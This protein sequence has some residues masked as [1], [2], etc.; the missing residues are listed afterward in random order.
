MSTIKALAGLIAVRTRYLIMAVSLLVVALVAMMVVLWRQHAGPGAAVKALDDSERAWLA[1]KG[2][3]RIAGRWE[4]RPFIFSDEDGNYEGY[5][6]DLAEALG[7]ILG[8]GIEVVSMPREEALI[9]LDNL[10][11]DAIMGL[12]PDAQSSVKYSFSEPYLSSAV[13]VFVRSERLDVTSLEDLQ[14]QEVAVQADTVAEMALSEQP[15]I[16]PVL[17]RS[18]EEGLELVVNEQVRALVA[19]EMAGLQAVQRLGLDG[20]VKLVGLPASSV[21]YSF[22]VPKDDD[23]RL[24]ILNHALASVEAVG[25][26]KQVDRAWFGAPVSVVRATSTSTALTYLLAFLVVGL[27]AGN[28]SYFVLKMRRRAEKQSAILQ[29]SQYKY[30]KLVEGT[31]EAVFSISADMSL[32]EVNTKMEGLT[33]YAKHDVLMR[34]LE[35]LVPTGQRQAIREFVR[36]A[37]QDGAATRDDLSLVDRHGDAVPVQLSAHLLSEGERKIVQCIARDVRERGRMREQV[38]RRSKDLS[39]INLIADKVSSVSDLENTLEEVLATVLNRTGTEGGVIYLRGPRDGE[40]VPAVKQGLTDELMKDLR[41]PQGPRRFADEVVS[42]RKV[43]VSTPFAEQFGPSGSPAAGTGPAIQAGVPLTSK[44]TVHGVMTL[45][46]REP[47]HFT[48][49]D[50]AL[51]TTVG[52]QIGVAIENAEL[53]HQLQ[54]S[55]REMTAVRRFSDSVLEG[56]TNGLVV[57]DREA[58]VRLLNRAG[59]AMLGCKEDEALNRSVEEFLPPGAGMVRDSLERELA[60]SEAEVVIRRDGGESTALG[61]SVS[62]LR[63][64]GGKVNGAVVMLRDLSK[65]KELEEDRRRLD[66]LALLGEIS[67]VMAHEIRNPLAG[68]GAGIQ[69][70]LTKFEEG[71]ER[72][73]AL[74]RVL[75]EGERVNRI[76]EDILLISRPPRLDLAPCDLAEL[77]NDVVGEWVERAR[78][79]GVEIRKYY[80]SGVPLVKGDKL[81]LHQALSNLVLNAIEAM[82]NGGELSISVTGAAGPEP[83]GGREGEYVAVEVRD[84]GVGIK[85]GDVEKIWDPFYT[86]KPRGTGLGLAITRRIIDEHGGE[87]T[88]K[89]EEGRGTRFIVK[90]PLAREGRR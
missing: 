48:D 73:Q 63:G 45:Y 39:T 64:E 28:V 88:L 6:V 51:L 44:D 65:E 33:G 26:K 89:S 77:A 23:T 31:D 80:A 47:R 9:A 83:V 85:E 82:P 12:A 30:K 66:R 58:K 5:E 4:E 59:E 56:M 52:N 71:D 32:L 19:D 70:L 40:M 10:E 18:A 7:P 43:L 21:N 41:W 90:L 11:V 72:H 75:K 22:A 13:G 55:V 3:L 87:V 2:Q 53:I 54:R 42:T 61:M 84:N 25:L 69:H 86:T 76:I 1:E 46:G 50:I 29:E 74:E 67:A 17:V 81:R 16:Y 57:V 38:W 78:G 24:D 15:R 34:S 60:Y 35:D 37:F 27:V 49:E 20:E 8:V 36:R 62:P 79:Q 14:G 68:M